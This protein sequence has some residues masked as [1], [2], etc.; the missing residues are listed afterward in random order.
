[1]EEHGDGAATILVVDDDDL[2]LKTL[3]VLVSTLGYRCLSAANGL[4]AVDILRKTKCD[5]V[6]SDL[7]M[8]QMD[9]IELLKYII[10]NHS[11]TDVIIATGYSEQ[12][13]Y[14]DVI[15]AGAIDF[16]KKPIDQAELEAKLA[17]ALRERYMIRK[18]EALSMC[19]GLT[20][21]LNRRAF[22]LRFPRE[23]E[24]AYRQNYRLFLAMIDIDNFKEYNDTHGHDEGDKVL[25]ALGDIMKISTR[26]SVD[27]CFRLGGDEFAVLLPQTTATQA[28][29]IVQRIL[30]RY[31]ESDFGGTTL[32]IGIIS[33]SRDRSL[34]LSSDIATMQ[35][36]ADQAMY[37]A[38]HSGKN[39][40][41]CRV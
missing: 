30:L 8:P 15:K 17:R 41:V 29:E 39:C 24:R 35:K 3:N 19:D 38:K 37:D 25:I 26:N 18:L 12:T 9:G 28:T 16:I 27:L 36:R 40:V 23:V 34:P 20:S 13:S 21:L 4:E 10:R 11:D 5:I 14:A 22:D 7:M 33:C 6:L 32:S 31:V 2:V 1:M